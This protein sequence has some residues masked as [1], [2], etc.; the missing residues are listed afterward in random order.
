MGRVNDFVVN[1][2]LDDVLEWRAAAFQA[3]VAIN[4]FAPSMADL[5]LPATIAAAL[6]ER[7]LDAG[8]LTV[9]I[10]EDL[11]LDNMERAKLVLRQ[12]REHGVRIAI[13]D[14]G[15]GY[16]ALSY[17]RELT[18]DE[19]KLDR[20]FI[21]PMLTD[22]RAAAVVR[23]V[24]DLAGELGLS[25]VAEGIENAASATWLRERGCHI[26]QGFFLSPPVSSRQLIGM[27]NRRV[28]GLEYVDEVG[29]TRPR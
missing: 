24:I 19:V 29:S 17:M 18:V 26:G 9:E 21:A 11:F 25:T 2:A 8:E 12:L 20:Q 1:K 7:G 13:D 15:S 16:S 5:R 27:A 23:A 22:Q 14:F 4:I 28:A 3:P 6:S 10:T